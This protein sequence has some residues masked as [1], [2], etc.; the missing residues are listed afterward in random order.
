MPQ[1][2]GRGR[3]G[4]DGKNSGSHLPR[5]V[6]VSKALSLTLRHRAQ[7][8]GL[9][10]DK[11]GYVNVAELSRFFPGSDYKEHIA[12]KSGCLEGM[13]PMAALTQILVL[14][15]TL[16]EIQD[17]VATND[18]QRFSL[19]P[20]STFPSSPSLSP[21]SKASQKSLEENPSNYLIRANQGHSLQISS[22]DLLKP[23]LPTDPDCPHQVVHG[24]YAAAWEGIC[25]SGGLKKMGRQ[26][27][28]F[29]TGIPEY[30]QKGTPF[31]SGS[32]AKLNSSSNEKGTSK[33]ATDDDDDEIVGE[34]ANSSKIDA[35][36][37]QEPV[38]SGMR[39]SATRM[40]WVDLARSVEQGRLKW[41]RSD[42]GVILTEGDEEGMV[43]L[44]WVDRVEKRGTGEVLWRRAEEK[45]K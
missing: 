36:G 18:K 14:S 33:P 28:H 39:K 4:R 38:I 6:Q 30:H 37:G 23:I 8:D 29:S 44:E 3:G 15:V 25:K 2:G 9:K 17:I 10:M 32:A 16:S 45:E 35:A 21:S 19:I 12:K 24:T 7:S 20:S 1:R 13:E 40:I 34:G 42:N 31:S 43:K 5:D 26:H 41:W 27:I 22:K 11:H